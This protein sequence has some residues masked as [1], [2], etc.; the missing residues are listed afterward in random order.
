MTC[1]LE[2]TAIDALEDF[3]V[4]RLAKKIMLAIDYDIINGTGIKSAKGIL[5]SVTPIETK[6]AGKID[7]ED[8]IGLFAALKAHAKKNA[9][10][11][12]ST[13]TLWL[14]LYA[15]TDTTKKPIFDPTIGKIFGYKPVENDDVPD[16]TIIFGDFSEYMFNWTKDIELSRSTEAQFE[17]GNTVFRGLALGDGG[18]LDLGAMK[19]LKTKTSGSGSTSGSASGSGSGSA[20]GSGS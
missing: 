1:E 2:N 17:S 15:I 4:N 16:G 3:V 20:S 6:T 10:L 13:N 9:T 5:N 19:V 7:Y 8:L 18:L 11:M 14:N 12:M